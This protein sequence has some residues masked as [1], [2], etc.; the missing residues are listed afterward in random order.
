LAVFPGKKEEWG[1]N[2]R[3]R[4]PEDDGAIRAK[5]VIEPARGLAGDFPVVGAA[6]WAI[7]TLGFDAAGVLKSAG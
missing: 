1:C 7:G 2:S 6:L 3:T 5:R 4:L